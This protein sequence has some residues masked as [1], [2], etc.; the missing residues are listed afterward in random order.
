[1]PSKDLPIYFGR[2]WLDKNKNIK[3][4]IEI[5]IEIDYLEY[6][7][8]VQFEIMR[9]AKAVCVPDSVFYH[10]CHAI[11]KDVDFAYFGRGKGIWQRVKPLH[12][13]NENVVYNLESI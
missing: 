12:N 9:R 4:F 13:V 5:G 1:M 8:N 11:N 2:K 7:I 10:A 6:N 3:H